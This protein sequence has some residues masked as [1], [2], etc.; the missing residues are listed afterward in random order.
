MDE[1]RTRTL[2][3][4]TGTH[5]LSVA[6]GGDLEAPSL[7]DALEQVPRYEDVLLNLDDAT[8]TETTL[9]YAAI[10]SSRRVHELARPIIVVSR[11]SNLRWLLD[12]SHVGRRVLI[13]PTLADALRFLGGSR[14]L[15][16]FAEV[17]A[18]ASTRP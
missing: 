5:L 2:R 7:A 15:S 14:W 12:G 17:G 8:P 10:V 11:D 3:L 1:L 18:Y 6:R 9:A 4:G 13:E 16:T